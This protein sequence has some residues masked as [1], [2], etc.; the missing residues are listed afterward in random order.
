MD[1]AKLEPVLLKHNLVAL[2]TNESW[3]LIGRR[4]YID[5]YIEDQ[6]YNSVQVLLH[7]LTKVG[8]CLS[9]VYKI[10]GKSGHT[11]YLVPEVNRSSVGKNNS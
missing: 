10:S 6:P 1:R 8:D 2:I 7:V 5:V 4:E 3:V 9:S 11:S